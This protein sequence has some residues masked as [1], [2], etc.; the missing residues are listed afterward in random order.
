M[1]IRNEYL[2]KLNNKNRVQIVQ[3]M[4][5]YND[6]GKVYSIYRITS[7]FGGKQ[8]EQPLITIDKGKATRTVEEQAGLQYASHLKHYLNAGYKQF[9]LLSNKTFT[10]LSEEELKNLTFSLGVQKDIES[11]RYNKI[12]IAT[13]ADNDGFHIRNLVMTYLLLFFEELV[14][15]HI[16]GQLKVAPEHVDDRV[17]Y[18]MGKPSRGLYDEFVKQYKDI[19]DKD[20]F[21]SDIEK[22]MPTTKNIIIA[23]S[24]G[25]RDKDGQYISA[26]TAT[27]DKFGHAQL[28]GTGKCLELLVKERLGVKVRSVEVNVLQRCAA[29]MASATDLDEGFLLGNEA[30][31][32]TA[33][34]KTAF[35]TTLVRKDSDSYECEI[36]NVPVSKVANQAKSVPADWIN[37]AGN[38][39]TEEMIAYLTP[40]V[41]GEVELTY[42]DGIVSY[43][44]IK[45]LVK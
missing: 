37:D 34:G 24:E 18:R 7:Q 40:L 42:D 9:S 6:Y 41:K 43:L 29:H 10:D 15:H 45:H 38:D 31:K 11:L 36:G 8:S 25:I 14:L 27:A 3:I 16:S 21:I 19:N 1:I 12:I 23:V 39:V 22:L 17:L 20:S 26:T 28:S 33:S 5:D 2:I 30:V 4:L 13:D 32:L 35:M 44:D